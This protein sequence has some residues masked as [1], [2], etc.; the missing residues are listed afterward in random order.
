M[1]KTGN[2]WAGTHFPWHP[3]G[4]GG[5]IPPGAATC[6]MTSAVIEAVGVDNQM[7]PRQ[8]CPFPEAF[9]WGAG[10]AECPSLKRG[11]EGKANG[12]E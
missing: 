3:G 4:E 7:S 9:S 10:D 5:K 1:K 8:H 11:S 12:M 6:K 2:A